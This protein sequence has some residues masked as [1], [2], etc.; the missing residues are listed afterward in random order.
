MGESCSAKKRAELG[1]KEATDL[2]SVIG[3]ARRFRTGSTEMGE[4]LKFVGRFEAT[5]MITGEVSASANLIVPEV[6]QDLIS[7]QMGDVGNEVQ[8]AA[9]MGV[10]PHDSQIG[11][12]W[13]AR[14]II[15]PETDALAAL[16]NQTTEALTQ[17]EDKSAA[18]AE[19]GEVD[20]PTGKK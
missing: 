3:I 7:S 9:V 4:F 6:M 1:R 5:N 14:P 15:E 20:K 11:Y 17:L 8:F 16:R 13:F 10:K 18:A 2:M 12:E 19:T